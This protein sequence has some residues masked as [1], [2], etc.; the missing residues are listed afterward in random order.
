MAHI[1]YA[2]MIYNKI[3]T[4]QSKVAPNPKE[5]SRW[6]DLSADPH[7]GVMKYYDGKQWTEIVAKADGGSAGGANIVTFDYVD[8]TTGD[9]TT[10]VTPEK[11]EELKKAANGEGIVLMDFIY[12]RGYAVAQGSYDDDTGGAISLFYSINFPGFSQMFAAAYISGADYSVESTKIEQQDLIF[13]ISGLTDYDTWYNQS[14]KSNLQDIVELMYSATTQLYIKYG[15]VTY[16]ATSCTKK[17]DNQYS[18][19]VEIPGDGYYIEL[20]ATGTTLKAQKVQTVITETLPSSKDQ[21]T[22]TLNCSYSKL[23]QVAEG[24]ASLRIIDPVYNTTAAIQAQ[25]FLYTQEDGSQS[26][27]IYIQHPG[28]T[29]VAT[30]VTIVASGDQSGHALCKITR[31]SYITPQRVATVKTLASTATTEEIIASYNTLLTNLK[32]AELMS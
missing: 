15:D 13:N 1:K 17:G 22:C 25:C 11:Y 16:L 29:A 32:T 19:K 24:R 31:D 8:K 12:Y 23:L 27:G 3:N 21:N 20:N 30:G 4:I 6:I 28:T 18:I 14:E 9:V 7:G 2:H 10:S 5:A 26:V